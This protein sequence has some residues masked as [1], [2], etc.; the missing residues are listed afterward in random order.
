[1]ARSAETPTTAADGDTFRPIAAGEHAKGRFRCVDCA[2]AVTSCR[3]L[4]ECPLCGGDQWEA[5][6]WRPFARAQATSTPS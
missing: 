3:E 1:M 6:A 5:V 2:Y 4:P